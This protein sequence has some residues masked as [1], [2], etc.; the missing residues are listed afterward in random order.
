LVVEAVRILKPG[1]MVSFYHPNGM[2][3]G[4]S[5]QRFVREQ[6]LPPR[7]AAIFLTWSNAA[8]RLDDKTAQELFRGAGVEDIR[9]RTHLAGMVS[10]VSGRRS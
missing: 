5:A 8:R 3:N 1:G 2:M 9:L 10:S 6:K 4:V 7:S